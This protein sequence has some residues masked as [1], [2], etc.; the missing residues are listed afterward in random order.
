MSYPFTL[1]HVLIK[2]RELS[3]IILE[4][5][6]AH[7]LLSDFRFNSG[8]CFFQRC[9]IQA[10]NAPGRYFINLTH[11]LTILFCVMVCFGWLPTE[12]SKYIFFFS[13]A[14]FFTCWSLSID[15]CD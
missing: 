8:A 7:S 10:E 3:I 15:V 9:C 2:L 12:N 5:Y 14:A 13:R 4:E 11:H 6:L 1:D